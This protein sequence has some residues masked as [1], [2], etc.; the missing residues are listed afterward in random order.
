MNCCD[1]ARLGEL[2]YIDVKKLGRIPDGGGWRV[3]GRSETVR[4]RANGYDY[5]HVAVTITPGWPTSKP[6]RMRKTPPAPGSSTALSRAIRQ[7]A[8]SC[9]RQKRLRS[10]QLAR[11]RYGHCD[12]PTGI[13]I[14]ETVSPGYRCSRVM[15]TG[16]VVVR[17]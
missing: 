6:C 5:L 11:Y 12:S 7:S 3:R 14:E 8:D 17:V 15:L 10:L 9:D 2:L 16:L 4:R 13:R 1:V